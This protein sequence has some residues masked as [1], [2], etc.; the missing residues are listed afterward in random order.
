M[1]GAGEGADRPGEPWI[2]Q[3]LAAPNASTLVGRI[4]VDELHRAGVDTVCAAPGSRSTPL[5][6]A[7]AD[8]PTMQVLSQLDERSAAFFAVG[9]AK[10]TG[11]PTP[12]ITT[13]GTATAN[14]HPAV[15]EADT[16]S[17]PLILLTADRPRELQRSGANQ[18]VD[19]EDLYGRAV[20]AYRTLP[21]PAFEERKLRATRTAVARAIHTA[22]TTEPGP[23]HL[24]CPFRKPLEPTSGDRPAEW[25]PVW[26][27][28]TSGRADG[29][30]Y[31]QLTAGRRELSAVD[32]S[33]LVDAID[34]SRSGLIVCGPTDR[35]APSRD[36]IRG[37]ALS[38]GFPVLADPL[39][40]L[41]WGEHTG[42]SGVTVCGGYDGYIELLDRYPET[43]LRFGSSPTSKP[44]RRYLAAAGEDGTRQYVIDPAAGWREAGFR[45]T[46]LVVA[47]PTPAAAALS[48][49]VD[50]APGAFHE[51]VATL[52]ASYW[53]ALNDQ[54]P[55]RPFIEGDVL[56][57]VAELAPSP[58][59]LMI[60]NSM[61]IR[62]LDRFGRPSAADLTV[63]GNRGAS[64]IDGITSTGLGAGSTTEEP[65]VLVLGDL[66]FY[67][68][69]NGLLA[70]D[71]LGV[72]AT[73]VLI[74]NDGG[75]IFHM[76]PVAEFEPAFTEQFLTPHGLDFEP[77]AAQFALEFSRTA[78]RSE[79]RELFAESCG[80]EG[81]QVIEV[82]FESDQS[83]AGRDALA[84]SI[85]QTLAAGSSGRHE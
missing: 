60:S 15:I 71:R 83:H 33:K 30:P 19:Q 14:L 23:V 85:Q 34:R 40:D 69:S 47:A 75:G 24:N 38:T 35:P 25:P 70:C 64:G 20:R 61:P 46:D 73:I 13:S 27:G 76:L 44:L 78:D 55:T 77:T 16:A 66:A 67:H 50:R 17:V 21:E 45:A 18:T 72:D 3:I 63:L 11:I 22:T 48:G 32:R 54:P 62:D 10:R 1:T 65:L 29:R 6:M 49:R 5:T 39:S 59:T 36:A 82:V 9:R 81:T 79:F 43:V 52:E 12:V 84:A 4:V 51:R 53:A 68:D 74:N 57:D 2:E 41:R 26:S 31:V 58:A 42:A 28:G 56:A 80:A 37:L 8:H 7:A